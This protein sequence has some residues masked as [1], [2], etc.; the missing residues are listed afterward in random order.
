MAP[1]MSTGG[2]PHTNPSTNPTGMQQ[3][4]GATFPMA[5]PYA[6]PMAPPSSSSFSMPPPNPPHAPAFPAN[7][8]PPPPGSL[9]RSVSFE[10]LTQHSSYSLHNMGMPVMLPYPSIVQM[11]GAMAYH[12]PQGMAMMVQPPQQRTWHLPRQLRGCQIYQQI[13]VLDENRARL[14][15]EK[16]QA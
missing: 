11:Q 1:M 13:R 5:P 14:R 7:F 8:R 10:G 9:P 2:A 15:F 4:L 6:I 16:G 12:T 3:G